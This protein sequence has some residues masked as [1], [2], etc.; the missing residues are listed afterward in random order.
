MSSAYDT[1][2]RSID[3][4]KHE[5]KWSL[6]LG[7]PPDS[8]T[9]NG[10]WW[11]I[12]LQFVTWQQTLHGEVSGVQQGISFTKQVLESGPV[13]EVPEAEIPSELIDRVVDFFENE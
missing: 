5:M 8:S 1:I 6:T 10:V 7:L 12:H 4:T 11:D 13:E 2:V 3:P 9:G